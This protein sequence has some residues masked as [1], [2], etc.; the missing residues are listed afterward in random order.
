M[1]MRLVVT[2]LQDDG[3]L[4]AQL[5]VPGFANQ[6]TWQSTKITPQQHPVDLVRY[7]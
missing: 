7:F 4:N 1:K 3:Q 5:V 2:L 6:K